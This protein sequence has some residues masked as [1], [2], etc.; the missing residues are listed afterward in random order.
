MPMVCSICRDPVKRAAVDRL[1]LKGEGERPIARRLAHLGLTRHSVR[2]H[3]AHTSALMARSPAKAELAED[4]L[5][6]KF[7][8]TTE[9]LINDLERLRKKAEAGRDVRGAARIIE[10]SFQGLQ[11]LAKFCAVFSCSGG[12]S[13]CWDWQHTH[14]GMSRICFGNDGLQWRNRVGGESCGSPRMQPSEAQTNVNNAIMISV[15]MPSGCA[16]LR[17]PWKFF[18]TWV[19]FITLMI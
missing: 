17:T 6:A 8:R 1:L 15:S 16:E 18:K 5:R 4:A 13:S 19:S 7:V 3:A 11:L 12:W 14:V 9:T 2:R 10:T